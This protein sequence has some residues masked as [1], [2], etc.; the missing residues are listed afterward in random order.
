MLGKKKINY[1]SKHNSNHTQEKERPEN[2]HK[3]GK[4]ANQFEKAVKYLTEFEEGKV[5]E[6]LETVKYLKVFRQ[7]KLCDQFKIQARVH[8]EFPNLIQFHY[9]QMSDFSSKIC[10]ECRGLI[11]DQ[12]DNWKIVALPFFKFFD[13][14]DKYCSFD[15]DLPSIKVY[16]KMDGSL[17]TLYFYNNRWS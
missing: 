12:K 16:E 7:D 15:L 4:E 1:Y 5:T 8:S 2:K 10:C 11:L 14:M 13:H 3:E 17:A 6:M 9:S